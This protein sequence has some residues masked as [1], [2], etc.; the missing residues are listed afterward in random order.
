MEKYFSALRQSAL[1]SGI[2]DGDIFPLLRCLGAAFR[3]YGKDETVLSSGTLART[4]GI[5][6]SGMLRAVKEDAWGNSNLLA[7]FSPGEIFAETAAASDSA[8][9]VG[10]FAEENSVICFLDFRRV[11][12]SC[13]SACV[14]HTALVRNYIGVLAA[15]NLA[16]TEKLE[17]ITKRTT[18]EKALSYLSAQSS[19]RGSRSFDIPLDR[20]QLADYL[21]VD[22]SALSAELSRLKSEG[23][24]AYSRNHFTLLPPRS[25]SAE[26]GFS[27]D[28]HS[29]RC[30]RPPGAAPR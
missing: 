5:V 8:L 26:G 25:L 28:R 9:P 6:A 30:L 14:F 7:L 19:A 17:H 22:R 18:R 11:V 29:A 12:T 4:V 1:F 27:Q 13:S 10:V 24:I 21:S 16:L 23:V 15:R 3:S 2:A 20:Q